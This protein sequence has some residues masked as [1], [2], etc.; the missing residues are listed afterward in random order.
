MTLLRRADLFLGYS[1]VQDLGD[2]RGDPFGRRIGA[3]LPELQAAQ[4]FPLTFESPLAR[5]SIRI[6]N[7]LRWNVA[8]QYY[9][10]DER[11]SALQNYR[12]HT[13]YTSVLWS[14]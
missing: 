6:A 7:K 8:Y 2:G 3:S 5:L 9:R 4:V 11:F 13:G 1:R 12:A 10:Y 14:F